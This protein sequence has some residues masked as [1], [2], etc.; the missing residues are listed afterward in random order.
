MISMTY[1]S[2]VLMAGG[3]YELLRKDSS[4]FAIPRDISQKAAGKIKAL[5]KYIFRKQIEKRRN[6]IVDREIF[7]AISYLRN[8]VIVGRNTD[9]GLD[10][11]MQAL[12]ENGGLL[13]EAFVNMLSLIRT[14]QLDRA[15]EYFNSFAGTDIAKDFCRLIIKWDDISQKDLLETL[16]SY[17]KAIKEAMITNVRRQDEL[18]S[19]LIYIPVI[20]NV[21]LIFIDFLCVA[22][23]VEQRE[24]LS[25]VF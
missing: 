10:Y 4:R 6:R 12:C 14:N 25:S 23:F 8:I 15:E 20:I 9:I 13:R 11:V 16:I 24:A 5:T 17:E 2:A 7:E 3:I 1:I 18:I 22:F 19:N 21:V